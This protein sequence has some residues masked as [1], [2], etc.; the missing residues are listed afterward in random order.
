MTKL[1]G[2]VLAALIGLFVVCAPPA[3][4]VL[5]GAPAVAPAA[6]VEQAPPA[7]QPFREQTA[8]PGPVLDPAENARA[9][10]QKTK[11]KLIAG[12]VALI[13]LLLVFVGR[14]VRAKKVD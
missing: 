6:G 9:D 12:G 8:P 5:I 11:S 1:S 13:L 7:L 4:A 2:L 10:S 3:Q 14:K